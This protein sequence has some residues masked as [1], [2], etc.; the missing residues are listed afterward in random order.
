MVMENDLSA[1]RVRCGACGEAITYAADT[2]SHPASSCSAAG[3]T[4]PA[5]FLSQTLAGQLVQYAEKLARAAYGRQPTPD[6]IESFRDPSIYLALTPEDLAKLLSKADPLILMD[7]TPQGEITF[8]LRC[9]NGQSQGAQ[10]SEQ[11]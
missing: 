10:L 9:S 6:E 5:Y 3:A 2:F 8:R 11:C 7:R 1:L 4:V